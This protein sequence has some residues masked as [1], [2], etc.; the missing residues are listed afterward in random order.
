MFNRQLICLQFL[1]LAHPSLQAQL[2]NLDTTYEDGEYTFSFS[3][4][5]QPVTF[6]LSSREGQIHFNVPDANQV[7]VPA[8]W[9]VDYYD[10][11]FQVTYD[12]PFQVYPLGLETLDISFF[13]D[14]STTDIGDSP[15][16]FTG[17]VSGP[18]VLENGYSQGIEGERGSY[19]SAPVGYE[20]FYFGMPAFAGPPIG[21]Q[22]LLSIF[23]ITI[24]DI[25]PTA[26]EIRVEKEVI[27]IVLENL[28]KNSTYMLQ[29]KER[30]DATSWVILK[31]FTMDDLDEDNSISHTRGG[32]SGFFQVTLLS[33]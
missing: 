8:D 24:E 2:F 9:V 4:S 12:G 28:I 25:V 29:Y 15:T 3:D 20:S 27:H 33:E 13:S 26:A 18:L 30:L 14:L 17:L 23:G 16:M 21:T 6:G 22:E 32:L 10:G 7:S 1:A 19:I 5:I 11:G 31:T